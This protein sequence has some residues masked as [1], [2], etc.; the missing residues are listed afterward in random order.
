MDDGGGDDRLLP[1]RTVALCLVRVRWDT[2]TLYVP[3]VPLHTGVSV[4]TCLD[5]LCA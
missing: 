4:A 1:Q 2:A 5:Q 3:Y